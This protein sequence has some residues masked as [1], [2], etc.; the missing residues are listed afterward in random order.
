MPNPPAVLRVAIASDSRHGIHPCYVGA[1]PAQLAALNR[2]SISL[3]ELPLRAHQLGDPEAL[4]QALALDPL[5][6]ASGTLDQIWALGKEMLGV[7]KQFLPQ[8]TKALS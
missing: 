1:L 8:F 3:Q 7:K 2:A 4:F 6:A 5:T